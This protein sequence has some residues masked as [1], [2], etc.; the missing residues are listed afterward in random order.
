M[1]RPRLTAAH[2]LVRAY[3]VRG[4]TVWQALNLAEFDMECARASAG[5]AARTI[6]ALLRIIERG[7]DIA[8][9]PPRLGG[10]YRRARAHISHARRCGAGSCEDELAGIQEKP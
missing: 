9:L 10:F 7:V 3:R 5:D 8:T 6:N 4:D 2:P 1:T